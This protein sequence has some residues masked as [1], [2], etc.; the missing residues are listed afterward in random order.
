MTKTPEQMAT[1][2]YIRLLTEEPAVAIKEAYQA[3]YQAA[4][5]QLTNLP[6][7]A[8]WISAEERLP[9]P[10]VAV[11]AFI[12]ETV[13]DRKINEM[14]VV[15]YRSRVWLSISTYYSKEAVTHWMPLPEAPKREK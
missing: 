5:D 8:K 11:L 15:T 3:G 7:S 14:E 9:E 6:T 2:W 10:N 13:G 12:I 1:D 4:K